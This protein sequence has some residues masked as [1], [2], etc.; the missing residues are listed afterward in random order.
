ME[1]TI[2]AAIIFF[3]SYIRGD[4]LL[5]PKLDLSG[6]NAALAGS[7]TMDLSSAEVNL[8]LTARSRPATG[9]GASPA[10][11]R[12]REPASVLQSLTD[13]L[14]GAVVRLEVTGPVG[15]PRVQTKALPVLEDSLKILG[16]PEE[17][18]KGKR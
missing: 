16:T 12:G 6:R 15:S 1:S 9:S 18:R 13:G 4:T 8:T 10:A 3:H 14:T 17:S 2:D 5:I 7:G 11:P